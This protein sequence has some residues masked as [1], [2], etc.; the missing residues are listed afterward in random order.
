MYQSFQEIMEIEKETGKKF[1]EI[2]RDN[3]C[4]EMEIGEEEAFKRMETMYQAMREADR[5]YDPALS[6]ASGLVGG[7]GEKLAEARRGRGL[8]CGP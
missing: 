7:D 6:S 8:L 2:V 5:S 1:W 3:D 4:R